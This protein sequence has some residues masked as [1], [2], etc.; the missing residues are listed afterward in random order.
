MN[1]GER[2]VVLMALLL[3]A[4]LAIGG[5]L[6]AAPT[7]TPAQTATL[8]SATLSATATSAPTHTPTAIPSATATSV[9]T[10]TPTLLPT[11][12][13]LPSLTPSPTS[14]PRGT[15]WPEIVEGTYAVVGVALDDELNVRS[16]PGADQEI[17]G[18]LPPY[19]TGVQV[20]GSGRQVG[21]SIWA[22]LSHQ[23]LE[24]W[25]NSAYLAR[26]VGQASE[27]VAMQA[28]A[29]IQAIALQ[30]LEALSQYVHPEQGVRF[31]PYPYVVTGEEGDLV[32]SSDALPALGEDPTVYHWGVSD[33]SGEPIELTFNEYWARFVYDADYRQP[34]WIG[35]D[36]PIGQG[37]TI[38]NIPE[39][40]P[41]GVMVEYHF[42]G[43]D[44]SFEGLDWRS[45]RLVL[46]EQD[47]AWYLVGIVHAE[48]TI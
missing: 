32:F 16:A 38:N 34:Q 24:G 21:S 13:P 40:Y 37:N 6:G 33:G 15:L 48:W 7:M 10:H 30:D 17:V 39:V 27:P 3:V 44:P 36:E 11:A 22:P 23:G 43:F 41:Q 35:F 14:P 19:A 5:C 8:P 12:T 4:M 2:H 1:G 45:L 47:G 42:E 20:A 25:A 9:P 31:S 29:I 46:E 18:A 26:Q 28:A